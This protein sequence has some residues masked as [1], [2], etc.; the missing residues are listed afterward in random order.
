[1]ALQS[2][3]LFIVERSGVQYKMTANQIADFV[4]AVRDLTATTYSN[5]I[6]GTFTGGETA[7]QGDRV[8]IADA[9]GDS[10]VDSGYAGYR[11]DSIGPITVT[12]MYEQESMDIVVTGGTTNLD[13]T[14]SAASGTITNDNGDNAVIPLADGTNAGLMS[15]AAFQ[16]VHP[17]ASAGL[18]SAANPVVINGGNQQ[19]T[20]N[21]TQLDSLP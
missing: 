6:A 14:P 10:S 17:P 4:G 21:I 9:S 11:I 8:F 20:F 5:M 12:K 19:V 18:T 16:N 15:P 1:M 7:K 3:D 2:T 13:Y